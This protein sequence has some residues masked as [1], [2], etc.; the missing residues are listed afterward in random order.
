ML[1]CMINFSSSEFEVAQW[2]I[3]WAGNVLI[4]FF[5]LDNLSTTVGTAGTLCNCI[6]LRQVNFN[7]G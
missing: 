6:I 5:H 4:I 1:A 3:V 2:K 7:H